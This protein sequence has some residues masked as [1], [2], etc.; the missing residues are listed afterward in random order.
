MN[1]FNDTFIQKFQSLIDMDELQVPSET[2]I[3]ETLKRIKELAK[4]GWVLPNEETLEEHWKFLNNRN[5]IVKLDDLFRHYFN[6]DDCKKINNLNERFLENKNLKKFKGLYEQA[7]CLFKNKSYSGSLIILSV[8]YEGIIRNFMQYNDNT[9]VSSNIN[10]CLNGMYQNKITI[11]FQDREA[12]K[13]FTEEFFK[14]LD[15]NNVNDSNYFN[16][17]ILLHG[18]DYTYVT[19]LDVIKLFNAIDVLVSLIADY[20]SLLKE[21]NDNE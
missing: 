21:L 2:E 17:N 3:K 5:D 12:I 15:F 18:I 16:R 4:T 8:I 19:D 14:K 6:D 10:K 20:E 9:G 11:I 1:E 13:I 7:L